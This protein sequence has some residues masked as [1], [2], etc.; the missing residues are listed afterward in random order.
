M[1][2][3]FFQKGQGLVE[4]STTIFIVVMTTIVVWSQFG[5][6]WSQVTQIIVKGLSSEKQDKQ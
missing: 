6:K 3:K 5:D 4:Y 2:K 1:K